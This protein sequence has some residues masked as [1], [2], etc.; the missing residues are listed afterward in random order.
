[1]KLRPDAGIIIERSHAYG[2]L[3]PIR[4]F[5]TEQARAASGAKRLH[6]AFALSIN[7]DQ[8]RALQQM[9]LL[10]SHAGL[11]ANGRARLLPAAIAMTM[12]RP[13]KRRLDFESHSSAKATSSNYLTHNRLLLII[14]KEPP[15]PNARPQGSGATRVPRHN[16]NF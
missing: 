9:E 2:D 6:C 13:D 11:R 1:M 5:A 16:G 7:A 3:R 15:T 10:F 12:V 14:A 4:P 8:F